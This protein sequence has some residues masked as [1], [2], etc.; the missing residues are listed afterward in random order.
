M[1][2]SLVMELVD[3]NFISK[4]GGA[5]RLL[6]YGAITAIVVVAVA[7]ALMALRRKS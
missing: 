5:G 3:S 4:G 2:T 7:V 1:K 6:L